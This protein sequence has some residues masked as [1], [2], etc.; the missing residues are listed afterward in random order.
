MKPVQT[1]ATTAPIEPMTTYR[2]RTAVTTRGR[3]QKGAVEM[4]VGAAGVEAMSIVS[5][6][7]VVDRRSI[8]TV[9]P[10]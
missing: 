1:N 9:A 10:S 8:P 6:R 4:A 2:L 5:S 3:C 7:K